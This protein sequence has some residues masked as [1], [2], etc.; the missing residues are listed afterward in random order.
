MESYESKVV[1]LNKQLAEMALQMASSEK[2]LTSEQLALEE[3]LQATK[4]QVVELTTERDKDRERFSA[5]C[6]EH[7]KAMSQLRQQCSEL[8]SELKVAHGAKIMSAT[9]Q[10]EQSDKVAELQSQKDK[11]LKQVCS[12]VRT[13]DVSGCVWVFVTL[14]N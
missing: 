8:Q 13:I 6:Q 5:Q 7:E 14:I 3:K 2:Q 12:L 11:I 1:T 10:E 4:K 9:V